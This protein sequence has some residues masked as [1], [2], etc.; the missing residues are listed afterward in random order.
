MDRKLDNVGD[1]DIAIQYYMSGYHT[2][3]MAAVHMV[4]TWSQFGLRLTTD[5]NILRKHNR[6]HS[7]TDCVPA[8]PPALE[9][10]LTRL[11]LLG[12]S[13]QGFIIS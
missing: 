5:P 3:I 10:N 9:L 4:F 8:T 2:K 12:T 1:I 11:G 6:K 13:F 7:L